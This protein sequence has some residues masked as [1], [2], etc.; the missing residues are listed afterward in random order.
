MK[1]GALISLVKSDCYRLPL[2]FSFRDIPAM[3][4]G[5]YYI[6]KLNESKE[7]Y[8]KENIWHTISM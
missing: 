5:S 1:N 6:I 3:C 7:E 4:L 8:S 2:F